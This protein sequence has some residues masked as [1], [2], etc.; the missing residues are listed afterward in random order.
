MQ[1]EIDQMEPS[2]EEE[3]E[4]AAA[5]MRSR[6]RGRGGDRAGSGAI[7]IAPVRPGD[8]GGIYT[9]DG[10]RICSITNTYGE[11][12]VS[13]S[14]YCRKHGCKHM[15]Q[16]HRVPY[17]ERCKQWLLDG[18]DVDTKATAIQLYCLCLCHCL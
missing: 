18:L 11:H 9:T 1:Y 14:I 2:E 3:E 4:A 17:P 16:Q 10:Q 7:A 15:L 8:S 13:V 12:A 5:N 6:G